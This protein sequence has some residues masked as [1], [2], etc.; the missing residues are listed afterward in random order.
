MAHGQE[1]SMPRSKGDFGL[2]MDELRVVASYAVECA[3][4]A[5]P[6]FEEA[7]PGDPRPRAAIDAAWI[8]VNGA[9][10]TTLQRV[11]ASDAHR[12]ANEAASEASE[13]AAHAAG[14]AAGAAYLHPLAEADQVSHI[15]RA[16]ACAA[17]A[18]ESNADDDVAVG[19]RLI[20]Q[21]RRRA[22]PTPID[23]L[24]RYPDAPVGKS[25]V[26]ILMKD[27]DSSLRMP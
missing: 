8:F 11:A 3:Q 19:E 13:H 6:L 25:R 22:T 2:T 23:V 10:R 21:A 5:L 20:K 12:A 14:D 4:E 1:C 15:L 27:L 26:A 7:N 9:A 16:A 24:K 17:R 18:A